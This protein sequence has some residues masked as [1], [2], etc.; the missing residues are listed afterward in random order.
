MSESAAAPEVHKWQA[1]GR[2]RFDKTNNYGDDPVRVKQVQNGRWITGW[3]KEWAAPG[4][5]LLAQ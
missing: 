4:A 2:R 3:R 5:K 1:Q